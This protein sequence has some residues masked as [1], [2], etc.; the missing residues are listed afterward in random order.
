MNNEQ[1]ITKPIEFE[2]AF[3]TG[4]RERGTTQVQNTN[5]CIDANLYPNS[6]YY[7]NHNPN[8][9]QIT[10]LLVNPAL[11]D[12]FYLDILAKE[13][14]FAH[15]VALENLKAEN[16]SK[17]EDKKHE[18]VMKRI[19]GIQSRKE[20][21]DNAPDV[22]KQEARPA[23][24]KDEELYFVVAPSIPDCTGCKLCVNICPGKKGEKALD[25]QTLDEALIKKEQEIYDYLNDNISDK[26]NKINILYLLP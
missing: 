16:A 7:P 9:N 22:V 20:E 3:Q 19:D 1:I 18:N 11:A 14:E 17:L 6:N 10:G 2:P 12:K 15:K 4:L 26:G 25:Y 21:L 23:N 24:I 5:R 8:Y 13:Q